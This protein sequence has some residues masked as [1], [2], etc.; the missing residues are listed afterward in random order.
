MKENK[1][2]SINTRVK[3]SL[4]D[5]FQALCDTLQ[6]SQSEMIAEF[7]TEKERQLQLKKIANTLNGPEKRNGKA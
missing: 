4:K 1:T 2:A 7:V 6:L 5:R 3:P